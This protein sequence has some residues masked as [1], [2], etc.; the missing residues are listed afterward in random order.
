[1][2]IFQQKQRRVH[3]IVIEIKGILLD[4]ARGIECLKG[5]TFRDFYALLGSCNLVIGFH[6]SCLGKFIFNSLLNLYLP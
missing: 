2:R 4:W 5:V 3:F 6:C 1:M